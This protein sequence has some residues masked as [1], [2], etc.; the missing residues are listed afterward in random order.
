MI[1]LKEGIGE[2]VVC[3]E[4]KCSILDLLEGTI[5]FGFNMNTQFFKPVIIRQR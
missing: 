4:D 5:L 1:Y 3:K 2:V